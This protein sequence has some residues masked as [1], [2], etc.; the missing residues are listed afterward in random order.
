MDHRKGKRVPEKNLVLFYW[1]CQ[2]LW[3]CGSQWTVENSERGAR[4]GSTYTKIGTIQRRLAWPL[5][6][7]DMQILE[8]FHIFFYLFLSSSN[9]WFFL[10]W[11]SDAFVPSI[12]I[13]ETLFF[14]S[15]SE[16]KICLVWN[17]VV[18]TLDFYFKHI[19]DSKLHWRSF[20]LMDHS[21]FL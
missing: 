19:V 10:D 7:D 15:V 2:S 16:H 20:Q 3:L 6:K 1:L 12:F 14:F 4:F 17:Q 11:C 21:D 9:F 5:H 8:A 18:G 13:K